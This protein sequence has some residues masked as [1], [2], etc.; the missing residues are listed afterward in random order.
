MPHFLNAWTGEKTPVFEYQIE[1]DYTTIPLTLAPHQSVILAF[2]SST[3]QE[4]RPFYITS[5][6][7]SALGYTYSKSGDLIA[8]VAFSNSDLILSD[9]KG[10]ESR[11]FAKDIAKTFSL[12]DWTLVAEKWGPPA[13]FNDASASSSRVNTTFKLP[14]LL[15]WP[16]IPGLQNTSGVGYYNNTFSWSDISLG[17][18]I[19]FGRVV[20]TLRVT[21]NGR[22]LPPLDVTHARADIS[23][24]LVKGTNKIMAVISTTM[25]NGL[26]PY[27]NRIKTNG[28][29]PRLGS[30]L[31]FSNI[32]VEAGLVGEVVII[33]YKRVTIRA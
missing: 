26:R 3:K 31:S 21:I 11:I 4:K 7:T 17:A 32:E 13:D 6:P 29:G 1:T 27:L 12:H 19:D 22:Q 28:G 30:G 5:G 18:F 2:L 16:L 8:K 24:Y 33:P 9:S 23:P 20:H 10:K 15:S 14:S 25:I